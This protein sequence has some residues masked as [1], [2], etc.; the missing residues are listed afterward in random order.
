VDLDERR[1]RSD[2]SNRAAFSLAQK[3]LDDPRG[4]IGHFGAVD[5]IAVGADLAFFNPVLAMDPATAARDVAAGIAWIEAKGLPASAQVRD[6][7]EP[8]LRPEFERIGMVPDSWVM[9]VMVLDPIPTAPPTPPDL[10][11]RTGHVELFDDWHAAL[12]SPEEIRRVLGRALVA[13]SRMRITVG[14]LDGEPVSGAAVIRSG[15]TIGVYAVGTIERARRRGIGRAVTWAAIEAG[16]AA[17]QS[18]MAILQSSEMGV[19]VYRSM[20]F[21]EVAGYVEYRRPTA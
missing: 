1:R 18:T 17:W 12:E 11:I 4:G 13:D 16:V 15:G 8:V 3:R 20:G 14:Y 5:A 2:A 7:V 10:M 21:V 9:P 6:D 19:P